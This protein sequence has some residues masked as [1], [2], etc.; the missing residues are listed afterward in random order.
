MTAEQEAGVQPDINFDKPHI[1]VCD[2]ARPNVKYQQ[3]PNLYDRK[4]HYVEAAEIPIYLPEPK[5]PE[6]VTRDITERR[7]GRNNK[8]VV[9]KITQTVAQVTGAAASDKAI[10][11]VIGRV[12]AGMRDSVPGAVSQVIKE[13]ARAAAA[14]QQAV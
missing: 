14:E 10:R 4:G 3:G 2:R 8:S 7:V 5:G 11:K 1:M 12:K 13:N 6:V 9:G